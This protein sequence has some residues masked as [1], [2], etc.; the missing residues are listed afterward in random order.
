[1]MNPNRTPPAKGGG[2]NKHPD[3]AAM[4]NT[5]ESLAAELAVRAQAEGDAILAGQSERLRSLAAAIRSDLAE[6]E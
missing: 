2:K 6:S 4:A 1:M 3:Y 5:L